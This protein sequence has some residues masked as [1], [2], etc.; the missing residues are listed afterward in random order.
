VSHNVSTLERLEFVVIETV[1]RVLLCKTREFNFFSFRLDHNPFDGFRN[2]VGPRRVPLK[3]RA[4]QTV[5]RN[6]YRCVNVTFE[7]SKQTDDGAYVIH[8]S[9]NVGNH[10]NADQRIESS[11]WPP[12]SGYNL[13]RFFGSGLPRLRLSRDLSHFVWVSRL[14]YSRFAPNTGHYSSRLLFNRTGF[15]A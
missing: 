8:I 15:V 10:R 12:R 9:F 1:F 2:F 5:I 11:G 4:R 14:P 3:T 6:R 7:T 13:P